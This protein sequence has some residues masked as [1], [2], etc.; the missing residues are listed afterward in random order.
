MHQRSFLLDSG[1]FIY[2]V[3]CPVSW[4]V[5]SL[6][7]PHSLSEGGRFGSICR[8][9]DLPFVIYGAIFEL[10]DFRSLLWCLDKVGLVSISGAI[11]GFVGSC[12]ALGGPWGPAIW[13]SHELYCGC[14]VDIY[15]TCISL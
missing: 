11:Y 13:A 9:T 4:L 8:L 5:A 7:L 3:F 14:S 6:W 1:L 10:L 15:G 2:G 12:V